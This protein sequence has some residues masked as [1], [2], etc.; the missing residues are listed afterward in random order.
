MSSWS[1]RGTPGS[2]EIA[3]LDPEADHQRIAYLLGCQVFAWDGERS[4]ELALLRTYAV[5]EISRV[6]VATGELVE[7]TRKRYDD[8]EL[9]MAEMLEHGYDSRRGRAALRRMNQMHGRHEIDDA[10]LLF[11]LSTFVLDPMRWV[12]RYGPRP[13]TAAER[14]ALFRYYREIGRRMGI[15]T[16]PDTLAELEAFS[17]AYERDRFAFDEAN[18]TLWRATSEM[19][20][21]MHLPELLV[22][23]GR[24]VLRALL[25]DVDPRLPALFGF[26]LPAGW[27]RALVRLLLRARGRVARLLGERR[28]PV[29]FT[30]R[31]RPTY[32]HGYEVEQLGT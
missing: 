20:L 30:R 21:E 13:H 26:E 14:Q 22:P 11:V 10:D 28:T 2:D 16:L 3:R 5:P 32:P 12:E 6:L 29:S 4:L 25:A 15:R 23:L 9:I 1:L 19:F 24:P 7:R 17:L 18:R 8:T 31:P 27:Q